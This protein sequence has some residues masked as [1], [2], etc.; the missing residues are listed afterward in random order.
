MDK[1]LIVSASPHIRNKASV[2]KIM[3]MVNLSLIPALFMSY[4]YFGFRAIF[5]TLVSVVSAVVAEAAIQKFRKVPVT[6][7]DGSAIL[8]GILLAFNVPSNIPIWQLFV[9]SLV[10]IGISK[11]SFGGLGCSTTFGSIPECSGVV[12]D[13]RS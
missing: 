3:H 11:M 8:T 5:L 4:Y 7:S 1:M 10:A 6:V 9:G 13:G 12:C 2:T